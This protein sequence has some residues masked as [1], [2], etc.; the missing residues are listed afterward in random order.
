MV[1]SLLLFVA[2]NKF[3]II[4]EVGADEAI[5]NKNSLIVVVEYSMC[6]KGRYSVMY[7]DTFW[8]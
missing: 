2:D 3:A 1:L 6:R 5:I 7:Y 4:G 8:K